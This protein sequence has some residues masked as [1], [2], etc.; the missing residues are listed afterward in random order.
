MKQQFVKDYKK[1]NRKRILIILGLVLITFFVV[2]IAMLLGSF[3]VTWE[4]L[5]EFWTGDEDSVTSQVITRI[6]L[7]R[8][9]A[10]IITG[11]A[12]AVSGA[13][14]Q[15]LLRNPLASPFTL[16][17][18]SSAAFG[19]AFA[20]MFLGAGSTFSS[21]ADAVIIDNQYIV[22]ASAFIWSLASIAVIVLLSRIRQA[23]PEV[24]ILSGVIL[25][26]LFSAG[27]SALQFFANDVQLASIM[28]WSFGDLGRASW[29]DIVLILI[30]LIPALLYFLK[31]SW[32]YNSLKT[33]DD[34]AKSLGVNPERIRLVGMV[35]ASLI[36]A[37]TVAFYGIIGFIGLVVPHIMRRI[38]GN[39]EAYL[40]PA[41]AIFGSLLLLLAD[42]FA[43]T[44]I[45][46]VILPV[47]II[48]SFIG[49]PLFIFLLIKGYGK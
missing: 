1:Y 11:T 20:I 3:E 6:R 8:I 4:N 44:I 22:A 12:L 30:F 25:S 26:S 15:S 13:V 47:G 46:P 21:A 10:A 27:I 9:I 37:F 28:F 39:H 2:Q 29:D 18:S 45:S 5:K 33:G 32:S 43:R 40:I 7:P 48:T 34:Y 19:A 38:I 41:S 14:S 36:T 31:N 49:A 23:N 17:I 24:I 42:T 35:V 16:G